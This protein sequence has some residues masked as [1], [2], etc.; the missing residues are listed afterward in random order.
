MLIDLRVP[1]SRDEIPD[2]KT[3]NDLCL[4]HE[5]DGFAGE[6]TLK[7]LSMKTDDGSQFWACVVCSG[8][9]AEDSCVSNST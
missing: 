1:N 9:Y 8:L 6:M 4:I 2:A 3:W 5:A 7:M